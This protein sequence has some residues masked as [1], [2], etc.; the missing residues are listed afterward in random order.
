MKTYHS[1]KTLGTS[2]EKEMCEVLANRGYWV[3]FMSPAPSGS[4]P[5]DIICSKNNVP[6]LIDCKT[7]AKAKFS[8]TRLEENQVYAFD[9]WIA[10]GN[11]SCYIAIK[12]KEEIH[13]VPYLYLKHLE[14]I[15]L[16]KT[17]EYLY[18]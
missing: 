1:N 2:F 3:H 16:E 9:K 8:I 15:D 7:S 17:R 5:C 14:K 13:L 6:W 18:I 12:Y 10:C 11:S 4:Q